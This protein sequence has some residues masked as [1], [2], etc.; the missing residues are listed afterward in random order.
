M[1][2]LP[3][4]YTELS[5]EEFDAEML[6]KANLWSVCEFLGSGQYFTT[7]HPTPEAARE[8]KRLILEQKPSARLMLYGICVGPHG[9]WLS[10]FM[11]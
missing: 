6:K 1:E 3:D 10:I 11:E 2:A 4:N 9:P 7:Y 8:E 5:R